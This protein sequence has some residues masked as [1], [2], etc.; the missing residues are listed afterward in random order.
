[1][2]D[3]R[4]LEVELT[5]TLGLRRRPVAVTFR[6]AAPAGVTKFAGIEPSGCSFWRIAA[7]GRT[8]YTVAGDHYNCP[9]GSYT[10]NLALPPDRAPE[11]EQTLSFMTSI[12]YL[13][14]ISRWRKCR[15]FRA[16]PRRR[17]WWCTRRSARLRSIPTSCSS[18]GSPG[19]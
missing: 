5:Q 8:F 15:G 10:H 11:L 6:D 17:P 13:K 18:R 7:T 3:Y 4:G 2:V 1:M 16:W 14:A 9:I 19:A 12:G